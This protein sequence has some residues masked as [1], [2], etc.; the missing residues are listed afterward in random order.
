MMWRQRALAA[1]IP[2]I[3]KVIEMFRTLGTGQRFTPKK[4]TVPMSCFES[5]IDHIVYH[6]Y[7]LTDEEPTVAVPVGR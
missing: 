3:T 5:G 4:R 2:K 7:G 1:N 6:L